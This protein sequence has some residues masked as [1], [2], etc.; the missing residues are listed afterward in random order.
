MMN[1]A[2]PWI[3]SDRMPTPNIGTCECGHASSRH[4]RVGN[5]IECDACN[6]EKARIVATNFSHLEARVT[7]LSAQRD[8]LAALLRARVRALLAKIRGAT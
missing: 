6:G 1:D 2:K 4:V 7:E 5:R 8:E 3:C